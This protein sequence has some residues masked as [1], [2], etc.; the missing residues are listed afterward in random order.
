MSKARH[1]RPAGNYLPAST[2]L[3]A[4]LSASSLDTSPNTA[5]RTMISH[6]PFGSL[7]AAPKLREKGVTPAAE[8][9]LMVTTRGSCAAY[10]LFARSVRPTM[11]WFF[12]STFNCAVFDSD[13]AR[14]FHA[15]SACLL[16]AEIPIPSPPTNVDAPPL[17]PGMPETPVSAGI[18]PSVDAGI[19]MRPTLP[20]AKGA[21]QVGPDSSFV[22]G[23]VI[24]SW[25]RPR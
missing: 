5:S 13:Q 6:G 22:P 25:K 12:A 18:E 10:W 11:S 8:T 15:A 19:G 1:P 17:S 2:L 21:V 20:V 9:L 14:K 23:A 7:N 16:V 4:S 24:P 3:S